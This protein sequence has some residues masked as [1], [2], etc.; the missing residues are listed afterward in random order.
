MIAANSYSLH[1]HLGMQKENVNL[2][3]N[4]TL[5]KPT[6]TVAGVTDSL[7]CLLCVQD[8]PQMIVYLIYTQYSD[9]TFH[10]GL[11][12]LSSNFNEG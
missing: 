6:D 10:S 5:L 2:S 3:F 12:K 9:F 8:P 4:E 11:L 7:Q 1:V